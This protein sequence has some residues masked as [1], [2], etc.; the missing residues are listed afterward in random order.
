MGTQQVTYRGEKGI[1]VV[2]VYHLVRRNQLELFAELWGQEGR[3][4]ENRHLRICTVLR[5][6]EILGHDERLHLDGIAIIFKLWTDCGERVE[7]GI[8]IKDVLVGE[9]DHHG[10]IS[11][12]YRLI[13]TQLAEHLERF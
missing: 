11:I 13:H 2:G 4:N 8:A 7:G 6:L 5:D 3:L 1:V 9:G 10:D 12:A